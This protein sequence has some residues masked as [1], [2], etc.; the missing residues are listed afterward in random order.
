MS[1]GAS[2]DVNTARNDGKNLSSP[3]NCLETENFGEEESNG[4][5]DTPCVPF[6]RRMERRDTRKKS[7]CSRYFLVLLYEWGVCCP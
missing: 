1:R 6:F 2:F 5:G 3:H 7:R 4:G